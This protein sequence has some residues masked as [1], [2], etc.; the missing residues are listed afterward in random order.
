MLENLNFAKERPLIDLLNNDLSK[1]SD[2]CFDQNYLDLEI[3]TLIYD[4]L[5]LRKS[6]SSKKILK[7][8][9]SK[10]SSAGHEPIKWLKDARSV[11]K[12]IK[13]VETS[14]NYTSSIYTILRDGYTAQNQR[15]G[16]YV[17][18]TSKTIEER[19]VEHKSGTKSGKGLE[20]HGIQLMRSLWLHGKVR[21]SKR[22]YYETK[23]HVTLEEVI[24]KVTGDIREDL[25]DDCECS[26][27]DCIFPF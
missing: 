22:F 20:K 8:L 23:V 9:L 27:K 1:L 26:D 16:V 2:T 15:Y 5:S 17:G 14:P 3:G 4:E 25:L 19:F 6:S 11:M 12:K 21:G 24:P 13:N 7:D 18:Q 10:F